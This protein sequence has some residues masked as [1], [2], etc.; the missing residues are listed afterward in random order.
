[1]TNKMEQGKYIIFLDIDGTVFDGKEVPEKNREA[2]R[3]ARANG[4]KVFLNTGRADC[5]VTKDIL[6]AVEPDGVV[7][8][9]GTAVVVDGKLV[10]SAI[11]DEDDVQ[12]LIRFDDERNM[13]V[14]IESV[15]K[16]VSMHGPAYLGQN[17][18]L[19]S[20][21]EFRSKYPDM[22][23]SKISFMEHLKDEDVKEL[24]K[25]FEKVYNHASYAEIPAKGNNKATGIE[26]VCRY[27]GTDIA[28]SIAMGDSGN[29][30]EM[31]KF[32][33]IG[34]AMGNAT[35]DIKAVAD[36]ITLDCKESGVAYA[37]D[38][39]LFDK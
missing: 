22:N 13:F 30:D 21:D 2:L 29:D 38:K 17:N 12:Y 33:G 14:I 26:H 20:A 3:R 39:L 16:L 31:I 23:V 32:S 24:Q 36:M 37:I 34:V 5:I 18:F 28:H 19:D 6:E 15:E 1:M 4:H 8:S 9:M 35:E 25:R 11:M 7:S 27:Y 10:Y